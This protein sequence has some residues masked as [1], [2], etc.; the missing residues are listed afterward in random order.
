MARTLKIS[1]SAV[2]ALLAIGGIA[3]IFYFNLRPT[4]L[5]QTAATTPIPISP[6][7]Q[8]A[9]A[10]D[11]TTLKC[12]EVYAS[13]DERDE[14]FIEFLTDYKTEYP[15]A[16][17][18]EYTAARIDFLISHNCIATLMNYGYDGTSPINATER[19]ELISN[20]MQSS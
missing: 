10:A 15:D 13:N 4:V 8:K 12:P 1:I 3:A 9:A 20:A 11:I 7:Q 5:P 2:I 17:F 19:Q 14:T 18:S 6:A 16:S